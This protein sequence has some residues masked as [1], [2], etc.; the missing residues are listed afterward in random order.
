MIL[1]ENEVQWQTLMN[2]LSEARSYKLAPQNQKLG[3]DTIFTFILLFEV[4]L[5]KNFKVIYTWAE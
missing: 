5:Y 2:I 4:W 3:V 1:V